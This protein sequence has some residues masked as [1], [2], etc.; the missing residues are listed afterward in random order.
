M[1]TYFSTIEI[2]KF[3]KKRSYYAAT[4]TILPFCIQIF[5]VCNSCCNNILFYFQCKLLEVLF[6]TETSFVTWPHKHLLYLQT[7]RI[8]QIIPFLCLNLEYAGSLTAI[9]ARARD[10]KFLRTLISLFLCFATK[11]LHLEVVSSLTT[12]IFICALR[13]STACRGRY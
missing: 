2:P 4:Y 1:L 8:S 12:E 10:A 5:I 13:R 9:V 11:A 7:V 3:S 6:I